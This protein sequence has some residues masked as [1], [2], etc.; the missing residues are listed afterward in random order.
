MRLGTA[1]RLWTNVRRGTLSAP[2]DYI[3]WADMAVCA[4][5]LQTGRRHNAI[6]YTILLEILWRIH[7]Y[8]YKYM[9]VFA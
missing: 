2:G 1:T 9:C 5:V 7:I 6:T 4:G 3:V 8:I